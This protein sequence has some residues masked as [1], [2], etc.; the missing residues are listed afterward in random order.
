MTTKTIDTN[1]YGKVDIH[2]TTEK[3]EGYFPFMGI[4]GRTYVRTAWEDT[5]SCYWVK[6]DGY[7][8]KLYRRIGEGYKADSATVGFDA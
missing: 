4:H 6:V 2:K 1:K 3:V 8:Y 7:W 5:N